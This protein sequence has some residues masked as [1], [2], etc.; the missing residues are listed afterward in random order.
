MEH[1]NFFDNFLLASQGGFRTGQ[2]T[3][4]EPR[5]KTTHTSAVAPQ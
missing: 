4:F 5:V 3:G 1:D 2:L